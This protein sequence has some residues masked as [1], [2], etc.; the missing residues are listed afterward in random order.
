MAG[1]AEDKLTAGLKL[2]LAAACGLLIANL[3]YAQPLAGIIGEALGMPASRAG[4][5]FGLPVAGYGVGILIIVPLADLA[6]NR[7]LV[8]IAVA[9][10]V[11]CAVV[12]AE[13]AEPVAFLGVAFLSGLMAAA[14]QVLVPYVSYLSPPAARGRAIGDVVSGLMLGIMLARP[15]S[16]FAAHV[17]S[18]QSIFHIAAVLQAGLFV[19]LWFELP[20]RRPAASPSYGELLRSMGKI[21]IATPLL[22]RRAFY[23]ASMFGA[24]SIFWTAVPLWLSGPRF[25]FTQ[26]GI[27]WVALAG[28]AGAIA[29]PIA[30]RLADK[31]FT[32]SGT[33]VAMSIAI[34]T[35]ILSNFAHGGSWLGIGLI[36]A[37]AVLLDFVV[38]ANLVFG[39][40]VIYG[41][42]PEQRS[43]VNA[44]YFATFFAGGAVGSAFSGWCYSRFGWLG[45]SALGVAFPAIALLYLA[46]ERQPA[47]EGPAV[48]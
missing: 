37:C 47:S 45:V 21:F 5:L 42:A 23:H 38:A 29:P 41:L 32:R 31:G 3:Y 34:F 12:I 13:L 4:L 16:S 15:A 44:L 46:T 33:V 24:F 9:L 6:E 1:D 27:A 43:R 30:G 36:V 8:L 25:L 40:R 20:A 26:A 22:R 48:H 18:W 11:V 28:V 2:L 39:Q 7:R 14:V 10:E 35:F 17:W 19:L